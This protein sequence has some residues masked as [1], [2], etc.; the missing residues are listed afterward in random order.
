M[1]EEDA[2]RTQKL[3]LAALALAAG[4]TLTACQENQG[5]TGADDRANSSSAEDPRGDDGASDDNSPGENPEQTPDQNPDDGSGSGDGPATTGACKTANLDFRTS[6]GMAEGNLMVILKNTGDT[7]RFK[8]FP[9]VDLKTDDADTISAERSGLAVPAVVVETGEESRFTLHVPRNDSGGSG[10]H[11]T[12]IVV[13]PP[14]ETHSRTLPVSLDIPVTDGTG[15]PVTVDPVGT[16][17]Q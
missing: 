9:G 2:M 17:K 1:T 5:T 14:D 11:I 3:T 12:S 16:G 10:V 13:T 7:C 15:K 8:G 4:L 6:P